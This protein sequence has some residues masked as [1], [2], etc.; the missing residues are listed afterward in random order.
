MFEMNLHRKNWGI[1][2]LASCYEV[3]ITIVKNRI[4]QTL[5]GFHA[6]ND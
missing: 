6:S 1:F 3:E 4:E 5:T 2:V